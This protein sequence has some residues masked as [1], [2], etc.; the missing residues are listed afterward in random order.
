LYKD[1]RIKLRRQEIMKLRGKIVVITGA[2]SGIGAASA[3]VFSQEGAAVVIAGRRE[4]EGRNIQSVV[5]KKG[6]KAHYVHAD[7]TNTNDVEHLFT[8]AISKFG[9]VDILFNNAGINPTEAR[10]PLG[11][12]PET[13]WD[14]VIRVNLKG[15]YL[16]SKAILPSMIKQGGG[17]I[18][19]TASI[20][21]LVGF[22]ERSA[23][24]ASKGAVLQL[25]RSMAIDYGPYNI[26]VNCLCPGM[27]LTKKVRHSVELAEREGRLEAILCDY[28]LRRLGS[29]KEIAKAAVF[30]SSDDSSWI[31]GVALPIDGGFTAR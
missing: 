15:I 28:P 12:C 5:Q 8:T 23:Y 29:T 11:A 25:T 7:I 24:I 9:K 31:T 19:N 30:F 10:K 2:T 13:Q 26:R 14:D 22:P 27:V 18:L 1:F 21:G 6:G 16:C 3:E 20:F 4:K 17:V